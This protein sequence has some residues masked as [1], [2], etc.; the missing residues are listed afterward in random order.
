MSF[1]YSENTLVQGSA[2]NLL[3]KE[4]GWDVVYAY[5]KE[6]LG[7]NGTLGRES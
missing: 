7:E 4:L 1:D 5:N 6:I 3:E 2:G